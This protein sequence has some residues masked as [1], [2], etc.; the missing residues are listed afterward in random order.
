MKIYQK[1][2]IQKIL[3][4][5]CFSLLSCEVSVESPSTSIS[6]E[7]VFASDQTAIA[8]MNG[9]YSKISSDNITNGG[10]TSTSSLLGISADE[11]TLYAGSTSSPLKG[12]YMNNL[13]ASN[14]QGA[15]FWT[16]LYPVIYVTN[17]VVEGLNAENG[18]TPSV[19]QQLIGEA[20]FM[21]ALCYFYLVNL[22]GDVP[23][24]LTTKTAENTVVSKSPKSVVWAQV[25]A[26]L[27]EAS[28]NLRSD[29]PD[30]NLKGA[31]TERVRPTKWAALAL[32]ARS[33]LYTEKYSLAESNASVVITNTALY[34]IVPVGS[35][36]LRNSKEAILQFQPT[37]A[38]RNSQDA[39]TFILT[40]APSSGRPFYLSSSLVNAFEPGDIR[41]SNWV[42]SMT[43]GT[44]TYFYPNKYKANTIA[45]TTPSTLPSEY[46]TA[47]RLSEQY[48]IRAEARAQQDNFSGARDD[49][50]LVRARAGLAPLSFNDRTSLITAILKEKRIELFSEW[51][52]RW[53]DLK[54]TGQVDAV[55][56]MATPLKAGTWSSHKQL[57]PVPE[58]EL[59]MNPN[60]IQNSGY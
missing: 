40:G 19:R 48:L 38:N 1:K 23:L 21:R 25:V 39:T 12:Y 22:Y 41:R 28:L 35:A 30:G 42:A 27:T 5:T 3:F 17:S 24:V 54:R 10:L 11:L 16:K 13:S 32:L 4:F 37:I 26:D 36:F 31:T 47:M 20:K 15:E 29:Y 34:E 51:G 59:R 58:Y 44:V 56:A 53:L 45:V 8:V 50:N 6:S 18:V 43:V 49:L 57:F 14:T 55:M 33:Y 9:V 46:A 52:H 2:S 60:M 7:N